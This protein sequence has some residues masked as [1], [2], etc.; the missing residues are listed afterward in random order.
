MVIQPVCS[1]LV[2]IGLAEQVGLPYWYTS[3]SWICLSHRARLRDPPPI[4]DSCSMETLRAAPEGGPVLESW[5]IQKLD[6][7]GL[8]QWRYGLRA[9]AVPPSI[10]I[11]AQNERV[12]RYTSPLRVV[13]R[14]E[15]RP[16]RHNN[17]RSS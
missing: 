8:I 1:N 6:G 5:R 16:A 9:L 15:T 11:T 7:L 3:I 10:M 4:S 14:G 2:L 13:D 17:D 12:Y